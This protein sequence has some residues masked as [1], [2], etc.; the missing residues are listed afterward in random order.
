MGKLYYSI[1]ETAD[2]LEESSSKVRYWSDYFSVFVKPERSNNGDRM[3]RSQDIEALQEIRYL[4][5]EKGMTLDGAKNFMRE[6]RKTV[7]SRVKALKSLKEIRRQ[8]CE[9]RADL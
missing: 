3:Y 5:T 7:E 8:L 1:G 2:I 9:I 6:N 4:V